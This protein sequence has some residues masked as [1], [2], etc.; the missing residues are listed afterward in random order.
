M[1]L[2]SSSLCA[3][4]VMYAALNSLEASVVFVNILCGLARRYELPQPAAGQKND[5]SAWQDAVNNSCAQ[6]EHQAGR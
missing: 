1:S 6:L 4:L 3:H 2:P 5:I